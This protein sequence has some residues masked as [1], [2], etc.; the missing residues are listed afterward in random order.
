MSKYKILISSLFLF[1]TFAANANPDNVICPS[2]AEIKQGKFNTWLPLYKENEELILD[3][4]LQKF[5]THVTELDVAK[6]AAEYLE[7]AHCFYR[8]TN[9]IVDRIVLG[10][11]AW[12]PEE[13]DHWSWL[14][15]K[16][17]AECRSQ[18]VA[19]CEFLK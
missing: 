3:N 18:Q 15:D 5:K 14:V 4:D 10:Q 12:R 11:D 13:D 9:P 17:F 16:K 2:I 19:D 7:S 6:W 1:I 8:G